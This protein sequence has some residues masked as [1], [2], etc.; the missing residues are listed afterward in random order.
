MKKGG[1]T[2]LMTRGQ[3]RRRL[4]AVQSNWRH[5]LTF[6]LDQTLILSFIRDAHRQLKA[7]M[8]CRRYPQQQIWFKPSP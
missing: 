4:K 8:R 5:G 2:P 6:L 7:G 3:A 1:M